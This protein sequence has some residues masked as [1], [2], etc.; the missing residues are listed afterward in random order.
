MLSAY[1]VSYGGE[2]N[3]GAFIL[4]GLSPTADGS[5]SLSCRRDLCWDPTNP[6]THTHW[7][8]QSRPL[9]CLF[10]GVCILVTSVW[11][12]VLSASLCD[13]RP[14]TT[15]FSSQC[16]PS[17]S[18]RHTGPIY[19]TTDTM[20]TSL[21]AL[22]ASLFNRHTRKTSHSLRVCLLHQLANIDRSKPRLQH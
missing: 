6:D 18:L 21:A 10:Y 13:G 16:Q 22:A 15:V 1:S 12:C 20:I 19:N 7:P 14:A 2:N 17:L 4:V 9:G 8:T 11:L 5:F 3:C